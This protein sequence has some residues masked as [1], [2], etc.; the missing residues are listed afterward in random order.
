MDTQG[1]ITEIIQSGLPPL[2]QLLQGLRFGDN[3]VWQVDRLEDYPYLA[4]AFAEQAIKEGF[5]CV[6]LSFAAHAAILEQ[7]PGLTIKRIDP[8]LG[9]D[10]FA[11]EVHRIIEERGKRVCYI[12][13]NLSDLVDEWATDEL[14]A[15][16]FQVTCP[17]LFQ[18]DAVAYFALRRGQHGHS[19]IA[20]V[21]DTTQVLI[22]VYHVGGNTYVQPLKV[23]DRYSQQMFLPHLITVD[24]WEP[25]S[26]SG[27]AAEILATAIRRPLN[28]SSESIAPWDTVYR[29]LLQNRELNDDLPT[30]TDETLVLKEALSRMMIGNHKKLIQLSERHL[31]LSELLNVRDR[32]IGSGRIGGKAAGM[33]LARSVLL[34][35]K[36][37]TDFSQVLEDHDSFYVGSDVFFTFLVNNDL[38]QLRLELTKTGRLS[39]DEFDSLEQ[40]FLEGKFSEETMEQFRGMIDYYGQA[41]IIVRSSSLLE[42]GFT[43]AFAGKYRSEFCANQGSPEE[44]LEAFLRAIKLVYASALNPDALAYRHRRGLGEGDEQMAVLV[45]R[46]SG[47]PYKQYFFPSLAGVAFSRNLYAWTDRIDPQK[48]MIRLVFGLGTRAVNRVSGDYPRMIAVSH[49]Q[50]RPET[51]MEVAKYSQRMVDV[52]NL[53]DNAFVT[54][55]FVEVIEGNKYPV[56]NLLTS[57]MA[58]GYLRDW[59]VTLPSSSGKNL[60]LTF[61]NLINQTALVKIIGEMLS[62]L[63]EAWGQPVDIE[64]TAYVDSEKNV[65]VN[66]LQCRTL[67]VP[68][69]V[70]TRVSIPEKLE[71]EHVLFRSS[72]AINAGMVDDIG[73]IICIDPKKYAEVATIDDKKTLGRVIGKL[74]NHLRQKGHKV[75]MMGPGR[76]GSNNIELGVNVGYADIDNT[77]VLV[78]V[79]R[80]KAGH[81]PEVSYGTHFFQDL[82]ESDI[83]YLPVYPDE[84][85]ADFNTEFFSQSPNVLK[86]LMPE[87]SDFEDIVHLIDVPLATDGA[88][89]KVIASPQTRKAVCFLDRSGVSNTNKGKRGKGK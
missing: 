79:A 26:R 45:Q 54:K 9:F 35:E 53:E 41:P 74:N 6:Y 38:F 24:G 55:P 29:K 66:L 19:A 69:L 31:A 56:L 82:V 27:D 75:M 77:A 51:G 22:D 7:R 87:L 68:T 44:R 76:W 37:Q 73:Y 67:R 84:A 34:S 10:Y 15:N 32:L 64:F 78:E 2:D 42:D 88:L 46:V 61:N 30:I 12:F 85:A 43:D 83:L 8:S 36:G 89:A 47:M 57:E 5:D 71:K 11:G 63:E 1:I 49:P 23:S 80:E 21:R 4:Q 86:S 50:I 16:F 18:V 48:G 13:D 33:L 25:I 72:R 52:L 3:V 60:I 40:K 70:G 39:R 62:R 81:T 14:L 28:V 59:F 17:Y 58:D 20:R 65:R